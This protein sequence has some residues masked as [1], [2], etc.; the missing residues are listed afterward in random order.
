MKNTK[1]LAFTILESILVIAAILIISFVLAG[2]LLKKSKLSMPPEEKAPI[3]V[4]SPE[5]ATSAI[6]PR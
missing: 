6:D 5:R 4:E 2:L 1:I 3:P